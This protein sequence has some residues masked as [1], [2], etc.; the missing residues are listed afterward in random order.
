MFKYF[1]DEAN[2]EGE[3]TEDAK[4]KLKK[5]KTLKMPREATK[6]KGI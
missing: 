1:W 3:K 2:R 4:Q 5:K 6:Q